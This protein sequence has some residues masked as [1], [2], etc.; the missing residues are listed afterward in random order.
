MTNYP[1]V[2]AWTAA[3]VTAALGLLHVGWA[4]SPRR[5]GGPGAAVPS[6]GDGKHVFVP[7]PLSTLAVAGAL[8][9]TAV[10][11]LSAAGI[12]ELPV[13]RGVTRVVAG[14]AAAAFALRAV[15]DFRYV[16]VFKRVVGTPFARWDTRLYTPL[17]AALAVLLA[18]SA[19]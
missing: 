12:L 7:G 5:S 3:A 11:T 8:G 1:V 13:G 17:C 2:A 9:V 4:V 10:A 14:L 18:V 16:G 6:G 15:G 19:V